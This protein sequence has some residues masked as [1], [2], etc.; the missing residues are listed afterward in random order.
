MK[1]IILLVLVV[2]SFTSLYGQ[3][4]A[5]HS[6]KILVTPDGIVYNIIGIHKDSLGSFCFMKRRSGWRKVYL[7]DINGGDTIFRI[8][9]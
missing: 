4:T 7:T 6:H 1:T 8:R 5:R 2:L 9:N 3:D